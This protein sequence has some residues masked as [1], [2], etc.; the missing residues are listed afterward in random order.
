MKAKSM[1][2]NAIPAPVRR[3]LSGG[4]LRAPKVG[5]VD[6]GDLR[7]LTP[8]SRHFGFDRGLPIDRHYIEG[9]LGN[10]SRDVRGRCLEIG[11]DDYTRRFGNERVQKS[12][13]LHVDGKNPKA[14]YVGDLSSDNSLPS[15]A[16]DCVI[17]TQTLQ[18]IYDV[19][20]AVAALHRILKPSGVL[21]MTVPGTISQLERGTWASIWHWGF[22]ALSIRKLCEE[23]FAPEHLEIEVHGNVLSSV[24]FLQGIAANELTPEELGFKDPLYPLIITTRAV[25]SHDQGS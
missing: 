1:I 5:G 13:V 23:Q 24:A 2:K 17:L 12:D 9:F 6:F 7:R 22:T 3:F 16:F 21:L 4:P 14:T 25:K 8:V 20:S 10:H 18:F 15:G 19:P 11:G